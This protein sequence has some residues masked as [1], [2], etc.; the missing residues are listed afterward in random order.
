MVIGKPAQY[1]ALSAVTAS[2]VYSPCSLFAVQ[3][4]TAQLSRTIN[5]IVVLIILYRS[6]MNRM[7]WTGIWQ[8]ST[9]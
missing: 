1:I 6:A 7:K 5:S 2:L 4:V 8:W 3:N 9:E